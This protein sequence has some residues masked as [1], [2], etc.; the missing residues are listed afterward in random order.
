MKVNNQILGPV[1]SASIKELASLI[2]KNSDFRLISEKEFD[3]MIL[4][5]RP[6]EL[7]LMA[8]SAITS[9]CNVELHQV[10]CPR[11]LSANF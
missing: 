2:K 7:M 10:H 8:Q 9:P 11:V 4:S 1:E 5:R 6:L 3:E